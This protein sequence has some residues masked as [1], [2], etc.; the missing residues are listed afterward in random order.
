[1]QDGRWCRAWCL[2]RIQAVGS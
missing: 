2:F 1:M